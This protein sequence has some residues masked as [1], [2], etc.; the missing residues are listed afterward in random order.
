MARAREHPNCFR[1]AMT[2]III[3]GLVIVIGGVVRLIID[4]SVD[5][6]GLIIIAMGSF[7]VLI[8]ILVWLK[9]FGQIKLQ[10]QQSNVAR[11][12]NSEN[13]TDEAPETQQVSSPPRYGVSLFDLMP[14]THVLDINPT[15][16]A[17]INP[18][19][20]STE[21]TG[22]TS[23]GSPT[24]EAQQVSSPPRYGGSLFERTPYSHILD[25]YPANINSSDE[26]TGLTSI[27]SPGHEAQQ[28]TSPPRYEALFLEPPPYSH[29]LYINPTER[30][31]TNS[32]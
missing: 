21:N 6:G 17:T 10:N 22:L 9:R 16:R 30:A 14:C 25:I 18:S 1:V 20:R 2:L 13:T 28:G 8:G 12:T 26:D 32:S 24:N 4:R 31:T 15:E 3:S 11:S 5:G 19:V 29:V 7:P 27:E 23:I